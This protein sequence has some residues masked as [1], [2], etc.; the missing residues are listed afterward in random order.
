[1]NKYYNLTPDVEQFL[2]FKN[3]LI[4][5]PNLTVGEL[6]DLARRIN[7]EPTSI[8]VAPLCQ[9]LNLTHK[10]RN[11]SSRLLDRFTAGELVIGIGF[12]AVLAVTAAA[13]AMTP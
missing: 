10:C 6:N 12:G 7:S 11:F 2:Q 5:Y 13:I 4:L 8:E 1:M 3:N 9:D